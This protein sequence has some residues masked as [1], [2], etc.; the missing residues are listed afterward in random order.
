MKSIDGKIG[1]DVSGHSTVLLPIASEAKIKCTA[2]EDEKIAV[3]WY[4]QEAWRVEISN[5]RRVEHGQESLGW[6]SAS[7][8]WCAVLGRDDG[9][10]KDGLFPCE[11]NPQNRSYPRSF[12]WTSKVKTKMW[13]KGWTWWEW[14]FAKAFWHGR[15][16]RPDQGPWGIDFGS[17]KFIRLDAIG[18][19][20]FSIQPGNTHVRKR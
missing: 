13:L 18:N 14:L 12:S 2:S 16:N 20:S 7:Q 8:A 15:A 19:Y 1:I 6:I 4:I 11:Q 5:V 17:T 3:A 10:K 9:P